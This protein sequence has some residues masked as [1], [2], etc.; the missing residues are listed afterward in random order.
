MQRTVRLPP[1]LFY[2]VLSVTDG[3]ARHITV[4]ITIS[5]SMDIDKNDKITASIRVDAATKKGSVLDVV[6]VVQ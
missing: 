5:N 3:W 1:S 2:L 4:H 6:R